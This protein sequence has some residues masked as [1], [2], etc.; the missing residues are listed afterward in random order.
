[1]TPGGRTD[2]QERE[3][4]RRG[5][6]R[7]RAPEPSHRQVDPTQRVLP[8]LS[9]TGRTY[10][11]TLVHTRS[12]HTR[13]RPR[14]SGT[15]TKGHYTSSTNGR[16][17]PQTVND[18]GDGGVSLDLYP[19]KRLTTGASSRTFVHTRPGSHTP[20]LKVETMQDR[21]DGTHPTHWRDSPSVGWSTPRTVC[22]SRVRHHPESGRSRNRV[23]R[24]SH[25]LGSVSTK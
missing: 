7:T 20:R 19:G 5:R 13:P 21:Y 8:A 16:T 15:R 4:K 18:T 14:T 9:M 2:W 6:R 24:Q 10:V 17:V 11:H 23:N 22:L 12:R 25:S 1:M 3:T